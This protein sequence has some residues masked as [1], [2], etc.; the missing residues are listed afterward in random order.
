MEDNI[1]L[2]DFMRNFVSI[3]ADAVV[4][5]LFTNKLLC[6]HKAEHVVKDDLHEELYDRTVS[7]VR[8]DNVEYPNKLIIVVY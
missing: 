3:T 6:E 1:R 4:V 2:Y 5:E 7:V 8:V